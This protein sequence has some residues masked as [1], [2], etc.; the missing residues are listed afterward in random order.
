MGE[1]VF[2]SDYDFIGRLITTQRMYFISKYARYVEVDPHYLF[3]DERIRST[4][5]DS[6]PNDN[7]STIFW[8]TAIMYSDGDL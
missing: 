8:H 4:D 2:A 7:L 6:Y 5:S 3:Y 1:I